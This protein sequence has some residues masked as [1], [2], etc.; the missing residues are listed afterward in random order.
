MINK[1]LLQEMI[2]DKRVMVQKHANAD[3][4]IYNYTQTTQYERVWNEITLQTRGLILDGDMNIV[5]RPF[6]KFFNLSEHEASEIP[7][8]PFEVFDKMDGSL[9]IL[10]W[11][12]DKPFIATRG[13]FGGEQA[14]HATEI[15]HHKY[16]HTFDKLKRNCTYLFEIIYP[17]NRIVV[18]YGATDDL[19][20]LAIIDNETG[21]DVTMEDIG[22]QQV[23][24]Y[25]GINDLEALKALEDDEKEGFVVRFSNGFRVKMK[26]EEYVRLHRIM[27]GISNVAI[28][29]Y[30]SQGK[31]FEDLLEKVP[32]EFYDWVQVTVSDLNG[33][34]DTI[35]AEAKS[36]YKELPTRKETAQYFLAQKYPTVLF[37]LLDGRSPSKNIWKMLRPQFAKP[38]KVC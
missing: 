1:L 30:L 34:F 35:L 17:S 27:T 16:A 23:K 19:V 31:S 10:Y 33:Q 20:L 36:V 2:Q 15:L 13:S 38:F 6:T 28:W 22:F 32:D 26:F 14:L 8:L 25:D 11:L 4:Y 7:Q 29:E 5:A 12:N 21:L 37:D 18:D 24:R 9:G 3:L